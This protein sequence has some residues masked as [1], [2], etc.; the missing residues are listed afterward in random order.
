MAKI[1]RQEIAAFIIKGLKDGFLLS[2]VLPFI[3][4]FKHMLQN[5]RS[6]WGTNSGGGG[7]GV[8]SGP[9][10]GHPGDVLKGR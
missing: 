7:G 1:D 6:N 3:L 5:A 2:L 8:S 9:E 10:V 4:V